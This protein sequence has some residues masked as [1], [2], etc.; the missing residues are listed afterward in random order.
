MQTWLPGGQLPKVDFVVSAGVDMSVDGNCV[1]QKDFFVVQH[2]GCG[3]VEPFEPGMLLYCSVAQQ[4]CGATMGHID[5]VY[6]A[7]VG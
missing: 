7:A 3:E 4:F 1:G 5:R 6:S 2:I